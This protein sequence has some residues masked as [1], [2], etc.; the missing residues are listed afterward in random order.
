M[1]GLLFA[2]TLL[3]GCATPHGARAP[4]N[5]AINA[6]SLDARFALKDERDHIEHG[7]AKQS[8]S[9]KL[10]WRHDS[11]GDRVLIQDPFG[12]GVAELDARM[13]G[14][15]MRLADGR[16]AEAHDPS[17]LMHDLTG[18]ALPIRDLSRWL[19]G[20]N[21]PFQSDDRRDDAGR[22][23]HIARQGWIIH[24]RYDDDATDALPARVTAENGQGVELRLVIEQWGQE[25][26]VVR[27]VGNE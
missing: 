25:N 24:Y 7:G 26:S 5:G 3:A 17:A 4:V 18:I 8:F 14:A 2:L 21:F 19:T 27:T 6:Y 16:V 9:G 20:R 15:V 11:A 13:Q 12:H 23:S 22:L 1:R 10:H